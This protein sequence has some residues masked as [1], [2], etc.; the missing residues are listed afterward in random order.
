MR[1]AKQAAKDFQGRVV[2]CP[3][4]SRVALLFVQYREVVKCRGDKGGCV[5][6]RVSQHLQRTQVESLRLAVVTF[7]I[8]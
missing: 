6:E 4:R 7:G 2:A 5:S 8:G 3:G 1:R